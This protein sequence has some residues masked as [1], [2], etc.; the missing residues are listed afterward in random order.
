MMYN[1]NDDYQYDSCVSRGICSIN[2][3]T[4][5]LQEVLVLYLKLT[6]YYAQKLYNMGVKDKE[7][8]KIIIDTISIMVSNPEFSENDFEA[9][10]SAFN[11]ILL[12]LI[13]LYEKTC[14]EKNEAIDYLKTVLKLDTKIDIIKSIQLGEKEFLEKTKSLNNDIRDLYKILFVLTK[15]MCINILELESFDYF[16]EA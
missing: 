14:D 2:P 1:Y 6:S 7:A 3:R 16:D 15:S 13:K 11:R 12:R 5:S 8:K 4:S 10:T 9:L